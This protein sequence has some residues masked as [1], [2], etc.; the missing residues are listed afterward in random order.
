MALVRNGPILKNV[1][2]MPPQL[3]VLVKCTKTTLVQADVEIRVGK[4][5]KMEITGGLLSCSL[6]L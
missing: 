5:D 6:N 4:Q 2:E 3:L 1:W